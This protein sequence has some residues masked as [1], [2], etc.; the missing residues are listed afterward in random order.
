MATAAVNVLSIGV[1]KPRTGLAGGVRKKSTIHNLIGADRC[2]PTRRK[3]GETGWTGEAPPRGVASTKQNSSCEKKEIL[4]SP[5]LVGTQEEGKDLAGRFATREEA[6]EGQWSS[7]HG[8]TKTIG[9]GV[10]A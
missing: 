9:V 4:E 8:E 10:K 7:S 2:R 3:K 6:I 1:L 5:F